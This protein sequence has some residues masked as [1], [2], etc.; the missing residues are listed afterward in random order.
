[1][2][3]SVLVGRPAANAT[4]SSFWPCKKLVCSPLR[5]RRL[6]CGGAMPRRSRDQRKRASPLVRACPN[7]LGRRPNEGHSPNAFAS[8]AAR[9]S[10]ASHQAAKPLPTLNLMAE[11]RRS[12]QSDPQYNWVTFPQTP[13]VRHLRMINFQPPGRRQQYHASLRAQRHRPAGGL[14]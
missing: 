13:I 3:W 1:M 10:L 5:L 11:E 4:D 7:L 2:R 12:V 14:G 8:H 9:H 6:M